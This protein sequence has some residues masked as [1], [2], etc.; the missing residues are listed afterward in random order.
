M[1]YRNGFGGDAG[2]DVYAYEWF[3]GGGLMVAIG[4]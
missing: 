3:S 2:G 4:E 1:V